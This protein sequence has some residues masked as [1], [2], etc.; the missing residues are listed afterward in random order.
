MDDNLQQPNAE[1]K[2]RL[3]DEVDE[4]EQLS[5][6]ED[7]GPDWTKLIP[8]AA[9]PIIPKR[10]D[11]EF[12]PSKHGGSGLQQHILNRSR[13][14][15]FEALRATRTISNKSV[16]YGTWHPS[17]SRV[18]VTISRGS[19]MN[20]IG[21]AVPRE[22]A[23]PNGIIKTQ[24]R[25]ELLPEEA[26]YLIERGS[27]ICW[28]EST[29]TEYPND[30]TFEDVSGSPM[31]VQQAYTEMIGREDLTMDRYQV[32]TYLKRLGY[33]VTRS[34]PPSVFYPV[35]APYPPSISTQLSST[36]F[37]K[38]LASLFSSWISKLF[39]PIFSHVFDWWR[40]LKISPWLRREKNYNF[41]FR[42]LRL[43][44]S[45][46]K[47]PIYLPP[48]TNSPPSPYEPFFNLYKPPT[49]F[50][51]S[52]PPPPDY[53]I[54][55]VNARTTPM[56][57]LRELTA[58]YDN[59]P[60]LPPPQPRIR[61]PPQIQGLS[62]KKSSNATSENPSSNLSQPQTRTR[63][64]DAPPEPD[65][66]TSKSSS[67]TLA[68]SIPWSSWLSTK[69]SQPPNNKAERKPNP[70]AV[71]RQGKKTAIIATVDAGTI[72]IFRFAQGAFETGPW[73]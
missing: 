64:P 67:W 10:G 9:R 17:L 58:I 49:P 32:Y 38:R 43:I 4:E 45:G 53:Q 35:A 59:A 26:I 55:V 13:N 51:K 6:D 48:D 40:P 14:A 54:V 23:M 30:G 70:F 36:S 42:S 31:T 69:S 18:S 22:I 60:E 71:L 19:A 15:M 41:I 65:G 12:E 46:H 2:I 29:I 68:G 44:P 20:S 72:N 62:Y 27:L 66:K 1:P 24:K 3:G 52:A 73:F 8:N 61:N 50:K 63:N 25:L 56:P 37:M 47:V 5:G 34:K 7:E 57:S 21:H 11:K 16:S 28:K 39:S 33:T